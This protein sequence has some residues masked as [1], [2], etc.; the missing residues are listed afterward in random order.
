MALTIKEIEG[1]KKSGKAYK[2]ADSGGLCLL[3][4]ASGSKLWRWRYH[5]EGKE[6]MMALGEY[7]FVSLADVRARHFEARKLLASG[8]D[9]MAKRRAKVEAT[10]EAIVVA[11]QVVEN[12]F[13]KVAKQWWVKWSVGRAPRHVDTVRVTDT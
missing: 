13:E 1:A 7:P 2:L 4:A 11:Q 8:S 6:K 5:F 9:P 3:V 12:S 10:R